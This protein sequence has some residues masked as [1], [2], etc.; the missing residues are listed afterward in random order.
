MRLSDRPLTE[1]FTKYYGF[2]EEESWK[3]VDAYREY[4]QDKGIFECKLYDRIPDVLKA[5]K[6]AGKKALVVTSKPEVYAKQIMDHFSLTPYFTYVAGMELDGGRGTKAEVIEYAFREN[7]ITDLKNVLM[8]GDRE[9]DVIGA[10]KIGIDCLGILYGFGD[11]EE[12]AQAGADYVEAD[13]ADILK[14]V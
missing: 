10:H 3:A 7:G 8:I 6:Q 2:S 5:V 12:F 4:Y 1:S 9:Y 14:Y 11:K 13:V